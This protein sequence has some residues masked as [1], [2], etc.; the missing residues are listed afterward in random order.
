MVYPDPHRQNRNRDQGRGIVKRL[1]RLSL[2][3]RFI[4]SLRDEG[5]GTALRKARN[6]TVMRLRGLTPSMLTGGGGH[7]P[8]RRNEAYLSGIWQTLAREGAFHV[9]TPPALLSRR[10]KI[11]L[12]ADMNLPQCRKYRVEQLAE[13]WRARDV[14]LEYAHYTDVPRCTGIMQDATH[15]MEYRLQTMPV[16]AMYRYEARRLRLPVLYDL[17]DP[18]FSVSAYE[19]YENMKAVEPELKAHF[20]AEAPKYLEMMNG[21]D[22]LTVSTPG[23]AEHTRLLTARPVHVR[24]NFA[25]TATLEAGRTAMAAG[26]P[27]DGLFRVCFASGSRGHEVDFA[28]I[29]DQVI[30]FLQGAETRRLMI[31]GHFDLKL[32]PE[33]LRDRV[34]PHGFA[35]YPAYLATLARADCTVTPLTDDIFNRC[36]SAVRVIDAAAAGVPS[37]VGTVGDMANMV[38]QGKTGFVADTPQAW[39]EALEALAESG[40]SA[41]MGQAARADLETRWAGSD[42]AHIIAPEVIAW[43]QE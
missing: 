20:V 21:A 30:A 24:R 22:I 34:E 16:T 28:Q 33:G 40:R 23:M 13:F 26:R 9:T 37:V 19:T 1:F 38:E 10:R 29:A 42:A 27:D 25:D 18:L 15:L 5:A 41:T 17:D 12:I 31:L 7:G 39:L 11:A 8:V 4:T 6:Y 35:D 36:K 32:L 14:E 3:R 43:V 2:V